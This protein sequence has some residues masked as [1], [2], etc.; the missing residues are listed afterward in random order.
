MKSQKGCC[1]SSLSRTTSTSCH[2]TNKINQLGSDLTDRQ[3]H[4]I[5]QICSDKKWLLGYVENL[6][7]LTTC[8]LGEDKEDQKQTDT[9]GI[10][11]DVSRHVIVDDMCYILHQQQYITL[12]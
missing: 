11:L 8:S 3:V 9:M 7:N 10:H 6:H 2:D 1:Y 5:D 4:P 12:Q